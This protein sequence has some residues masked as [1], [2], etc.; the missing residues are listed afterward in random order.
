MLES[1]E[2]EKVEVVLKNQLGIDASNTSKKKSKNL[3]NKK[4]VNSK[5][6]KFKFLVNCKD[7][8]EMR[9]G[10]FSLLERLNKK[11]RGGIISVKEV[12]KYFVEV[13]KDE[14]VERLK[15]RSWSHDDILD[16][17]YEEYVKDF[18]PNLESEVPLSR[19]GWMVL[20]VENL[21]NMKKELHV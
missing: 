2:I 21:K 8:E 20:N 11:D 10:L 14:D 13:I 3:N 7:D 19:A 12:L 18:T 16:S 6:E 9:T 17:W 4:N 5:K 15:K 1:R